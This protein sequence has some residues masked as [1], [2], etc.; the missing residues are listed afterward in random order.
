MSQKLKSISIAGQKFEI[1]AAATPDYNP[2]YVGRTNPSF[3]FE[4][5]GINVPSGITANYK[6]KVDKTS[7]HENDYGFQIILVPAENIMDDG[8]I[9]FSFTDGVSYSDNVAYLYAGVANIGARVR[10]TT[11]G[12]NYGI[13]FGGSDNLQ[14]MFWTTQPAIANGQVLQLSSTYVYD[15]YIVYKKQ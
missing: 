2:I 13:L 1:D 10:K 5:E 8:S 6:I 9:N 14:E 11:S 15:V 4:L 12:S 3:T 7:T